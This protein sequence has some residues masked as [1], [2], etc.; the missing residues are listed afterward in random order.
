MY[1]SDSQRYLSLV[2]ITSP[3]NKNKALEPPD[4]WTSF[5]SH[6]FLCTA[7]VRGTFM[8]PEYYAI[9]LHVTGMIVHKQERENKGK[10]EREKDEG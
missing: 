1:L 7:E 10:R 2:P 6:F 3:Q 4:N 5:T 8:P 9:L